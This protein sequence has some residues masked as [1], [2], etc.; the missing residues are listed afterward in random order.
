MVVQQNVSFFVLFFGSVHTLFII[1]KQSFDLGI[2]ETRSN[3]ISVVLRQRVPAVL[4]DR[5]CDVRPVVEGLAF[6]SL[7]WM[8][9]L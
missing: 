2:D 9:S 4:G 8:T 3:S 7:R 1:G 5:K 6:C